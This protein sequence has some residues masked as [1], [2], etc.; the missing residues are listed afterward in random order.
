MAIEMFGRRKRSR[1]KIA[2]SI[3]ISVSLDFETFQM[4]RE[5]LEKETLTQSEA[6]RLL[7][8]EGFLYRYTIRPLRLEEVASLSSASNT[9][10]DNGDKR[11]DS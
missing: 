11:L 8:E 10:T 5:T 4:I 6:I 2:G 3:H 9:M 7:I 1:R